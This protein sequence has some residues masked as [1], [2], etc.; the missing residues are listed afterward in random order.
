MDGRVSGDEERDVKVAVLV[1]DREFI[2]YGEWE[3]RTERGR[4]RD[5]V[6]Y[7][8][9]GQTSHVLTPT[10]L[11]RSLLWLSILSIE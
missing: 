8:F 4:W 9:P 10:Q 6:S 1:K 11:S 5:R 2:I 7:S 3:E